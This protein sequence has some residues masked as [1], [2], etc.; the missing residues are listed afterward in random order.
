MKKRL[1][2]IL[3]MLLILGSMIPMTVWASP[4]EDVHSGAMNVEADGESVKTKKSKETKV[5]DVEVSE[6]EVQAEIKKDKANAKTKTE[7]EEELTNEP[8]EPDDEEAEES[9]V[10]SGAP[11][12]IVLSVGIIILVIVAGVV[13]FIRSRRKRYRGRR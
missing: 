5:V 3:I 2:I 7:A 10:K 8:V 9:L 6:E 11:L 4:G 1:S 12:R 13:T